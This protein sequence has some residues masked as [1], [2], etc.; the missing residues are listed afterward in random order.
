MLNRAMLDQQVNIESNVPLI[1]AA[2]AYLT[3]HDEED[4]INTLSG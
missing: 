4:V 1:D 2:I 3:S